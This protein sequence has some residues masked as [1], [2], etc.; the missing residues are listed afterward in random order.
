MYERRNYLKKAFYHLMKFE[1]K[2]NKALGFDGYHEANAE[3]S[4][5]FAA[6]VSVGRN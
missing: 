5:A 2:K 4:R 3:L 6:G 1:M